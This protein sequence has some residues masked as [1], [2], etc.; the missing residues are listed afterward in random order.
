MDLTPK[1]HKD[2]VTAK[3]S[4]KEILEK[5][6]AAPGSS[7]EPD[8]AIEVLDEKIEQSKPVEQALVAEHLFRRAIEEG[9]PAGIAG[10]DRHGKQIYVNAVFCEMVGWP[11]AVL[12]DKP[13]PQPY[14][15][16]EE[17]EGRPVF[18]KILSSGSF[19]IQL[20][21]ETGEK[22][23]FLVY[24]N[25]LSDSAG[26]T[27]GRLISIANIEMQKRT[28]NA[29]RYLSSKLIDAQE[30]ERKHV[31]R[32]LHDSIGGKLAGIKYS[33]EKVIA[34]L[35]PRATGVDRTLRETVAAVQSTIAEAQRITHNLHPSVLDDLGLIS[36]MRGYCR[37]FQTVYPSIKIKL[38]FGLDEENVASSVKILVYR[39]LQEAMNNVA[40]HSRADSVEIGLQKASGCI[41]L[42]VV[43]NGT[44]FVPATDGEL[45]RTHRKLGLE[46]M[47]E[48]TELFGGALDIDSPCG[49]GTRIVA[50]WPLG[51]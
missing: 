20:Q 29:L 51:I 2:L 32:D 5:Q 17:S 1:G 23:W 10:F 21:R 38:N 30:Q 33:L 27:I 35:T 47:R 31:A 26:A 43:D 4:I 45:D 42:R 7:A 19:E 40:K 11:E 37:E 44:G 34:E 18:E 16:F 36:A 28:E 8:I 14:W 22:L 48:R 25:E 46:N 49:R 41:Q 24:S 39:V 3:L 50:S 15:A 6:K 13:F 12:I 9:I